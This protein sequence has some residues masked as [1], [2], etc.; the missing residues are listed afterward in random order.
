[1]SLMITGATGF[2]G[3]NLLEEALRGG[4]QVISLADR[5]L[6]ET[7]RSVLAALPGR[8]T[9][10]LAD[11]RDKEQVKA[12]IA[13]HNVTRVIHAAVITSDAAR[14]RQ[15]GD[16]IVSVNL[17]GTAAVAQ[18][19]AEQGVERFLLVGSVSAFGPVP[20]SEV[21]TIEEDRPQAPRSLY[22]IGKSASE[23][24]LRRIA[25]LHGMDVRIGRLGTVFGPWEHASGVRDTL[26]APHQ[27]MKAA[28][29]RRSVRL[30]RPALKNWHYSRQAAADLLR[31]LEASEPARRDYNLGPSSFW[32]L[33]DWSA[34]LAAERPG[35]SF[36]V[37]EGDG[38]PIELYEAEDNALLG[39]AAFIRDL[40]ARRE[41]SL[42]ETALDY[43][44]WAEAHDGWGIDAQAA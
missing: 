25:D 20:A 36:T 29:E 7:P 33:A 14:E 17:A 1:M 37:G 8:L 23:A 11:V 41:W 24:I 18:A 35:F 5:A 9:E 12:A 34:R 28:R 6:G 19:A 21:P 2:V 10:V 42:A 30:P 4:Q 3:I 39:S 15:Q 31:L 13:A 44:A 27:V 40:G 32:S 22:S 43:L 26:S 16:V 38:D